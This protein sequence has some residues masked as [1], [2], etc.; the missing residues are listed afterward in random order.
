MERVKGMGSFRQMTCRIGSAVAA[1]MLGAVLFAGCSDEPSA[2]NSVGNQLLLSHL[3]VKTDTLQ[4]VGS[5][6]FKQYVPMDGQVNLVGRSGGY[7]AYTLIQ[8]FS[9]YIPERDTVSV[10]SARL[11]ILG[12]TWFGDS[13]G[14]L[15]F[16][17]Y[18]I[19]HGWAQSTLRWDSVSADPG[20]YDASSARGTYAG[21]VTA[22][23]AWISVDLDTAMVR[24]WIQPLIYTD[25]YGI[26]LVPTQNCNVVR[27]V[28]AFGFG[29]DSLFAHLTVIA[30][31]VAGT[32]TDTTI[33]RVGQDTFL[34]NIDNLNTN[35][36]L[37]YLQSG[38]VY[39]S[40]LKFD[41]SSIP[42][43]AIVNQAR[44]TLRYDA[45]SSRIT[46]FVRDTAVAAHA[47]LDPA[48][49][50]K[51][52]LAGSR[53]AGAIATSDSFEFDIRHQVQY[54]LSNP[55]LNNGLLLRATSV[56]EFSSFGLFTFYNESAQDV[57][58]RPQLVVK[59]TVESN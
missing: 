46:R 36:S 12:E 17:V 20:F 15:S 55:S 5:S 7:T 23:S 47:L 32:V 26:I 43:G 30:R 19:N 58:R 49:F 59:Y 52:E 2:L 16:N 10:V 14:T 50:S 53:G 29:A 22:D 51:F 28:H 54:W 27:G 56:N 1:G 57:T 25:N 11:D 4:A 41:V 6:T 40:M 8:F 34:G 38:V 18:K 42:R 37:M 39:R 3:T 31:N 48:D 9:F 13:S 33:Y 24:R 45:G 44:L 21:T 35:A